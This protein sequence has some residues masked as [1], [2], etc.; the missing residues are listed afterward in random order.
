MKK[1]TV[2]KFFLHL[3]FYDIFAL[4]YLLQ[5]LQGINV[6]FSDVVGFCYGI[7][8]LTNRVNVHQAVVCDLNTLEVREKP[9]NK[10]KYYKV[11]RSRCSI[12]INVMMKE[13]QRIILFTFISE[14]FAN[15][16]VLFKL[17][18]T[19][20]SI[21]MIEKKSCVLSATHLEKMFL[22]GSG[23]AKVPNSVITTRFSVMALT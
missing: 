14:E 4:M 13:R 15:F 10:Q 20:K 6:Y 7:E 8:I 9:A 2:L 5:R 16:K 11:W 22:Q 23:Y 19:L 3:K 17:N 21:Q 18:F 12:F 1:C